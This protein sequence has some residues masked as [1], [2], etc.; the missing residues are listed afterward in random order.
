[1]KKILL[2]ALLV[3]ACPARSQTWDALDRPSLAVLPPI[4]QREG[5]TEQAPGHTQSKFNEADA[6]SR[7]MPRLITESEAKKWP[8]QILPP[9]QVDPL[10]LAT[11]GEDH[12]AAGLRFGQLKGLAEKAKVRYLL[13]FSIEELSSYRKTNTL[14]AMS[15]GRASVHLYIYDHDV[16]EYVWEASETATSARGDIGHTGSLSARQDQALLNALVRSVEPFAKGERKKIDRP[17]ASAIVTV[18]KLLADGQ[19]VLLD[20]GGDKDIY[21]GA[22]LTSVESDATL[23]VTEVLANGSIA[24]VTKGAP[25]EKEVF[26]T[27]D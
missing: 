14:Q 15:S 21:V 19:K 1:L 24:T 12:R 13:R 23:T 7:V 26:K 8:F 5:E 2:L 11:T 16:N 9:E 3:L 6:V 18:Q 17:K 25:K 22:V 27:A 10:S 20:L 4:I